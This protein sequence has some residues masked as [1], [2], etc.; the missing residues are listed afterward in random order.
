MLYY[1]LVCVIVEFVVFQIVNENTKYVS[2]FLRVPYEDYP[3]RFASIVA[4]KE[5][6]GKKIEVDEMRLAGHHFISY[7]LPSSILKQSMLGWILI[8]FCIHD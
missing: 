5:R 1:T 4:E 3:A 2:H 7:P 6:K 8:N